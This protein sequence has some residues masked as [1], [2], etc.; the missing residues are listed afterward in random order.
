MFL[1]WVRLV[2]LV[3]GEFQGTPQTHPGSLDPVDVDDSS[4]LQTRRKSNTASNENVATSEIMLQQFQPYDYSH[5]DFSHFHFDLSGFYRDNPCE[6]Q[7]AGLDRLGCTTTT[8][9]PPAPPPAPPLPPAGDPLFQPPGYHQ[10]VR[11]SKDISKQT[12]KKVKCWRRVQP[13]DFT[14]YQL[15]RKSDFDK[16]WVDC[17]HNMKTASRHSA[18]LEVCTVRLGHVYE[19]NDV[20]Q[21]ATIVANGLKNER[22]VDVNPTILATSI[23]QE[24]GEESGKFFRNPDLEKN[25]TMTG[26]GFA[27]V[28]D[29]LGR[30]TA[31]RELRALMDGEDPKIK[32]YSDLRNRVNGWYKGRQVK[33]L[34]KVAATGALDVV[35]NLAGPMGAAFSIASAVFD[36]WE[37][38]NLPT[39]LGDLAKKILQ[40]CEDMVDKA[41]YGERIRVLQEEISVFIGQAEY[42]FGTFKNLATSSRRDASTLQFMLMHAL[43]SSLTSVRYKIMPFMQAQECDSEWS[44]TNGCGRLKSMLP[45][46]VPL[47]ATM[48][49]SIIQ[50]LIR[51]M[52][53]QAQIATQLKKKWWRHVWEYWHYIVRF[54]PHQHGSRWSPARRIDPIYVCS[55]HVMAET[56]RLERF[57]RSLL[58]I[59][60]D[61]WEHQWVHL[62]SLES[63]GRNLERSEGGLAHAGNPRFWQNTSDV[64]I[65]PKEHQA[66]SILQRERDARARRE[67]H[68]Q[69]K[70]AT[71]SLKLSPADGDLHL[72]FHKLCGENLEC[73][74]KDPS[75]EDAAAFA[76]LS[77]RVGS[78]L[79]TGG[80]RVESQEKVQE[81]D[82]EH[83][84]AEPAEQLPDGSTTDEP[85]KQFDA[86][87]YE[88]PP[89]GCPN[90]N[91]ECDP[92]CQVDA[93]SLKC[94]ACLMGESTEKFC[95]NSRDGGP[96]HPDCP[97]SCLSCPSDFQPVCH[98]SEKKW[99]SNSCQARCSSSADTDDDIFSTLPAEDMTQAD[100]VCNREGVVIYPHQEYA[101]CVGDDSVSKE[102]CK[103]TEEDTEVADVADG[104]SVF[105][106]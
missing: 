24:M 4:M 97:N 28:D 106:F 67:L 12:C 14:W 59:I 90:S 77:R 30:F 74:D 95:S 62:H 47:L 11:G 82:F 61:D 68:Q 19:S 73:L 78:L 83:T 52:A 91:G 58:A 56:D 29:G 49:L 104:E 18:R 48:H 63:A 60:Y 5:Y 64:T 54:S 22:T 36:F 51:T 50:Q 2:S 45:L 81:F 103:D 98:K 92:P 105:G 8:P 42:V 6:Q 65:S 79:Q 86:L 44:C 10:V 31:G 7:Q 94:I 96:E 13:H 34:A 15:E 93:G 25:I 43:E 87:G 23:L 26:E 89:S 55:K 101:D 41:V 40:A 84:K 76:Q 32:T 37:T 46:T 100:A 57:H 16:Q 3:Y 35:S 75:E 38:D 53:G 21:M 9:A 20:N 72:E 33:K 71:L 69:R 80:N 70:R 27:A 39:I 1:L 99:F 102:N 88:C 66:I 85:A 17:Y